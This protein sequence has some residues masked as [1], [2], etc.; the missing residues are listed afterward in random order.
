MIC[1]EVVQ[2]Q[3]GSLRLW[4]WDKKMMFYLSAFS[5]CGLAADFSFELWIL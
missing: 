2:G 3:V 4:R 5:G 1:A